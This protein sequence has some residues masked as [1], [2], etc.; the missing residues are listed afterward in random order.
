MNPKSEINYGKILV[1]E[2]DPATR[3]TLRIW[4]KKSGFNP[5]F[6]ENG[7]DGLQAFLTEKPQMIILD[8]MLPGID[9]LD[10]CRKI[11][12]TSSLPILM[13]SARDDFTD[14]ILG[15][16]MGADDYLAKPFQPQELIA[17]V[18]AQLRRRQLDDSQDEETIE[19]GEFRLEIE[20]RSATYRSEPLGLTPTEFRIFQL[21]ASSPGATLSRERIIEALWGEDFDGEVRT[22]DSHARN[23]RHKLKGCGFADGLIESVWGVGYRLPKLG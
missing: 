23:L 3:E 7:P 13:L 22:V 15:L 9:G 6:A 4:L 18:R 11:R 5:V 16:E 20:G 1:V 14:K 8:V 2:D 19:Y 17:R 10:L 21:L 12:Q